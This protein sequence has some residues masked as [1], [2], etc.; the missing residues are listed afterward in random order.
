MNH[1]QIGLARFLCHRGQFFKTNS[2]GARVLVCLTM[3][4][5]RT[6]LSTQNSHKVSVNM[7]VSIGLS[8]LKA[9]EYL[10]LRFQLVLRFS[11]KGKYCSIFRCIFLFSTF[12]DICTHA[13]LSA[14]ASY[15]DLI[16][17]I[18]G[19]IIFEKRSKQMIGK[20]EGSLTQAENESKSAPTKTKVRLQQP[21]IRKDAGRS[22]RE[23]LRKSNMERKMI[24]TVE[25]K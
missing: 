16:I 22:M 20:Q 11:E 6:T 12:A 7:F 19:Q 24:E 1:K 15:H 4:E 2:N 25:K 21:T 3:H 14:Y 9:F 13:C 18:Y 17:K 5:K 10:F 8:I 23:T